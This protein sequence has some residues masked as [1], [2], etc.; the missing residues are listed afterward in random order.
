MP[1]VKR[2]TGA[3][4]WVIQRVKNRIG[5]VR[6]RSSG[7]KLHGARVEEITRVVEGHD[8][9][10][11][12][13]QR[14]NGGEARRGFRPIAR[15]HSRRHGFAKRGS[16]SRLSSVSEVRNAISRHSRLASA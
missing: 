5:V 13:A 2:N 10:D 15:R 7:E 16:R 9:H 11:R 6:A 8:D 1:A 3:Q 4:T 12:P 14:V